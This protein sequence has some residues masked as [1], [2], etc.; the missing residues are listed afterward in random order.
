MEEFIQR[1]ETEMVQQDITM[2]ELARAAGCGRPYLYR[3]L[4]REQSP[5]LE[6]AANVARTLGIAI[7]FEK[8]S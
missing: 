1:I 4:N 5:S 6:W 8:V 3:V 2:S 7:S